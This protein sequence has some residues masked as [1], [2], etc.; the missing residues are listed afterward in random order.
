MEFGWPNFRE[1]GDTSGGS[2][3][4]PALSFS[5]ASGKLTLTFTGTLQS[6]TTVKGPWADAPGSSPQTVTTTTGNSFYR[7]RQ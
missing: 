1:Y 7:A 3:G 4:A 6:A 2:S 5:V